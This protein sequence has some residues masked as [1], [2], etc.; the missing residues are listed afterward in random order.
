[1]KRNNFVLKSTKALV[2]SA[3]L[4]AASAQAG[5]ITWDYTVLGEFTSSTFNGGGA[6]TTPTSLTWDTSTGSGRSSLVIDNSDTSG[7]VDTF[8]GGGTPPASFIG[9]SLDL[10][11][12]NN[13]VT[14]GASLNAATLQT[15]IMLDPFNPDNPALPTQMFSFDILFA[16]T[17][18]SGTCA[19]AGSP[20]PCNDIFVIDGGLP[21]FNFSYDALDGDGTQDY[22]VN[23]FITDD[24]ALSILNDDICAA[25]GAASGCFGLT[26]IEGQSNLIPFGFTISTE[27]LTT[28]VPEPTS[29]AL[30]GLSLLLLRLRTKQA[31]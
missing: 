31:S 27:P 11:H 1:M 10:T 8:V 13:P 6:T 26:T 16:E 29:I 20:V 5:V 17:P 23:V 21:N 18:N 3:A 30:V 14:G 15:T 9:N 12:N 19:D 24:N 25:A 4:A 22:F 7:Q 28:D 2:L